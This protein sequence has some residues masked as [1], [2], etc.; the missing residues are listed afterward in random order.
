MK[1]HVYFWSITVNHDLLFLA[2]FDFCQ[3]WIINDSD[4]A[5]DSYDMRYDSMIL[6]WYLIYNFEVNWIWND[7]WYASDWHGSWTDKWIANLPFEPRVIQMLMQEVLPGLC[8]QLVPTGLTRR[9]LTSNFCKG[10]WVIGQGLETDAEDG[11]WGHDPTV[12]PNTQVI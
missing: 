9:A 1:W 11:F 5:W 7:M 10:F 8:V 3:P 2:L 12:T 4:S 6:F